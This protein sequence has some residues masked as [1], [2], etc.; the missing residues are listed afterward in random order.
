[1]IETINGYKV[2]TPPI[3]PVF[4]GLAAVGVRGT[5]IAASLRISTASVS[6][7]RNGQ[8]NIPYETQIF[9][10][11]MLSDKIITVLELYNGAF[12]M[13]RNQCLIEVAIGKLKEQEQLNCSIPSMAVWKGAKQYRLWWNAKNTAQIN[14]KQPHRNSGTEVVHTN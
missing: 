7:W 10:S 13:L 11:L 2:A 4:Q 5:D 6:K 1:M 8:T 14:S 12:G 9:L 3:A